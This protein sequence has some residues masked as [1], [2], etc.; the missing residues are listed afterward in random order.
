MAKTPKVQRFNNRLVKLVGPIF[1]RIHPS[2]NNP[3]HHPVSIIW[4][5]DQQSRETH[6]GEL[7][8][9]FG[10][11]EEDSVGALIRH[12][13]QTLKKDASK[14]WATVRLI[15]SDVQTVDGAPRRLS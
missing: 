10:L 13:S 4:H 11:C 9:E 14:S 6:A 15:G 5:I 3:S 2:V 1:S 12:D 7:G 8:T